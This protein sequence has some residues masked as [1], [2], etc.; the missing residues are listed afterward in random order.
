MKKYILKN[1]YIYIIVFFCVERKF[2]LNSFMEKI[3]EKNDFFLF[4]VG[5]WKS[6]VSLIYY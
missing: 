3:K 5:V 6:V 4:I 1:L 2:F